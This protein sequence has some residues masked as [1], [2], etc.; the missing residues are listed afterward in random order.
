MGDYEISQ[1]NITVMLA[2]QAKS[3]ND[4]FNVFKIFRVKNFNS[5]SGIIALV[6]S[7]K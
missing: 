7:K 1:R 2:D 6:C 5:Y 3:F 4:F